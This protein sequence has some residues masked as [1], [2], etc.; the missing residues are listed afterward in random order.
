[1]EACLRKFTEYIDG[2]WMR[3]KSSLLSYGFLL[4]AATRRAY[5]SVVFAANFNTSD[6]GAYT[7]DLKLR[8]SILDV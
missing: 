2:L 1:M 3:Y 5:T 6:N 8:N 7:K 4:V